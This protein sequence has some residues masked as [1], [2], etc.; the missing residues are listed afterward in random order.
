[1]EGEQKY[2][3]INKIELDANNPRIRRL[4]EGFEDK[5]ADGQELPESQI[6]IGLQY[7]RK[8]EIIED[9][10]ESQMTFSKLQ[11]SI[12][13]NKGI[14]N[15]II[16]KKSNKNNYKCIEGNTRLAIYKIQNGKAPEDDCW[17]KIK[18]TVYT[19]I[20]EDEENKIR[21]QC[22]LVP[23]RP[24]EPYSRAKYL[25]QLV[26]IDNYP[27]DEIAGV[28]GMRSNDISNYIEAYEFMEKFYRPY[29][30][31]T[32]DYFEPQKFSGFYELVL[33]PSLQSTIIQNNFDFTDFSK[34]VHAG[35]K[36]DQLRH[37]RQ[38]E[39]I[40]KNGKSKAIFLKSGSNKALEVFVT[41]TGSNQLQNAGIEELMRAT[42]V[43]LNL[44]GFIEMKNL[45][46]ET[47][48]L[49]ECSELISICKQFV[50]NNG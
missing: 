45:A 50:D 33:R 16:I 39:R 1:M 29:C 6:L 35:S 49:E 13:K 23:P 15:P 43:K 30:N 42:Y 3:D 24:W 31:E 21:L 40:L 2:I 8:T 28:C 38:L 9:K 5:L 27:I 22:H 47:N 4:M 46:E 41:D 32:G 11:N 20:T 25:N 19:E 17:K 37:V 26:N 48:F 10:A 7:D 44:I 12:I 14:L 18:C 34:W 36:I